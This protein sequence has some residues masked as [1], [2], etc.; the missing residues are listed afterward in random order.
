M[1][2]EQTLNP[3]VVRHTA[4]ADLY[5]LVAYLLQMPTAETVANL[6][7]VSMAD[8]LRAICAELGVCAGRAQELCVSLDAL[9]AA[10]AAD[11]SALGTVRVEHTRLFTQPR[12]PVLWPYE[13]LFVDDELVLAGQES[14][15][16]RM[17]VNP[18]ASRA[19]RAYNAASF[20][21]EAHKEP[22]DYVV[23]ELEF[24]SRLHA[25]IAAAVLEGDEARATDLAGKL[26]AFREERLNAW[27]PRFFVRLAEAAT[28]HVY[29]A[30]AA[31]G[32]LLVEVE[33]LVD[34]APAQA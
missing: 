4:T 25:G 12:R 8:D 26:D 13:G 27:I 31:V 29:P 10:L 5:A 9:Q 6:Q 30:A 19:E 22:A 7:A 16:A 34:K 14:S 21:I 23:T 28:G 20:A 17:F 33:A 24:A 2:E 15:E 1:S 32:A 3:E 11:N 18:A